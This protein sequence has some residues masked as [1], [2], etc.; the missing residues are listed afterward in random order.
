MNPVVG[1]NQVHAMLRACAP[2]VTVRG[3]EGGA[4]AS[5]DDVDSIFLPPCDR[6]IHVPLGAVELLIERFDIDRECARAEIPMLNS[7]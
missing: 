2:G 3:H 1:S 7:N 5:L 4:V 6:T